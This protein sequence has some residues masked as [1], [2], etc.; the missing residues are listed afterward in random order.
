MGGGVN[1]GYCHGATD[2]HGIKAADKKMHINDLHATMLY[3][4]GLDHTKL[5]TIMSRYASMA[6]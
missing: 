2:V 5:T 1:G 4:L 3:L 6:S